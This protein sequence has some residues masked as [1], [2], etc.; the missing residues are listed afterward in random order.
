M[1]TKRTKNHRI[2]H[3]QEVIKLHNISCHV[4]L[5]QFFDLLRLRGGVVERLRRRILSLMFQKDPHFADVPQ[6]R[7][8]PHL[9]Y[10]QQGH[11]VATLAPLTSASGE[12]YQT[13]IRLDSEWLL[14]RNLN[15]LV[16]EGN[17]WPC[18]EPGSI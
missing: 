2:P 13:H 16:N 9:L 15:D 17:A 6:E 3:E 4:L 10:A 12:V 11:A 14:P 5:A 1:R 18:R 7:Q 8:H